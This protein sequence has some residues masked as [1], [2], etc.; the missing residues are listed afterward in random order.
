MLKEKK[1][2]MPVKERIAGKIAGFWTADKEIATY[3]AGGVELID[4]HISGPMSANAALNSPSFL[5]ACPLTHRAVA[6]FILSSSP[7]PSSACRNL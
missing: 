6:R 3:G 7:L 4:T 2:K 1:P 5:S